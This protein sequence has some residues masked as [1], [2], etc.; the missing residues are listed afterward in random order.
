M[1]SAEVSSAEAAVDGRVE[2]VLPVGAFLMAVAA[3][4]GRQQ[5]NDDDDDDDGGDGHHTTIN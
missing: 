4:G 1:A 3:V 2:K 5:D